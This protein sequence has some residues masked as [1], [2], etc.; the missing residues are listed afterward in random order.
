[1]TKTKKVED[2]EEES[3]IRMKALECLVSMLKC[4]V[5]WSR[6]LYTNPHLSDQFSIMGKEYRNGLGQKK[7]QL[8]VDENGTGITS[9]S[10]NSDSGMRQNETEIIEQLERLKN[11]KAKLEGA[12]GLFNKKPKK[13][14]KAF[15]EMGILDDDIKE[16][17]KF[18]LREERL[19]PEAIGE[20]L[21]EGDRDSIA[22]MHAYVDMLAEGG[23]AL[24]LPDNSV[25]EPITNSLIKMNS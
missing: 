15:K 13:G 21:G 23:K 25:N 24:Y 9:T 22:L 3:I 2:M 18:L 8:Q 7:D 12:I 5:E 10:D 1:M 11:Q 6:E 4:M 17:A 20:L 14:I 16:S 19:R